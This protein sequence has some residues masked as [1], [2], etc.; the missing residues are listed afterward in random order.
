[1]T[2]LEPPTEPDY[3]RQG[4]EVDAKHP[5]AERLVESLRWAVGYIDGLKKFDPDQAPRNREIETAVAATLATLK[6]G[7][8]A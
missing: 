7:T 6:G 2:Y 8:D 3:V 5:P 4:M 1:M